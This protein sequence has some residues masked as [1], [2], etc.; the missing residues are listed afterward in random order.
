VQNLNTKISVNSY[1]PGLVPSGERIIALWALSEATLGGVLHA[2]R[3]P[4]TGLFVGS[5]AVI[6]ITM[7]SL[8]GT[9]SSG[10]LRAT[11]IVMIVKML[12]SPHTPVNAYAAIAF[13]GILGAFLFNILKSVRTAALLLGILSL[14]QSALQKLLIITLVFGLNFWEATD[15][16][17]SYV[18]G[19]IPFL[20]QHSEQI[21]FV[22]LITAVYIFLHLTAGVLAGY[23]A[24]VIGRN[25]VTSLKQMTDYSAIQNKFDQYSNREI[26][27]KGKLRKRL[28]YLAIV[29]ISLF[30]FLLSYV[31]PVFEE[32]RG[33]SAL[34]MIFRSLI[35]LGIWY[36]LLGPWLIRRM[37]NYLEKREGQYHEEVREIIT[38]FPGFK[39]VVIHCWKE[40]EPLKNPR[41]FPEFLHTVF[42]II[43]TI[44]T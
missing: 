36:Y 34:I 23:W 14:L 30:I 10:I 22:A 13:Q 3:L 28:T 40:Y 21:S 38:S 33:L 35:I 26:T 25:L 27:K 8:F 9:K 31:I 42:L 24:P 43:L 5:M 39:K 41:R 6:F 29:I 20:S 17:T 15:L 19:Q 1:N 37:R 32:S 7:L 4:L 18:L 11:L 12:I 16:F 2:L 44:E